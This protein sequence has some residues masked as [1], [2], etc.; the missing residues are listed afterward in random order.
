MQ[1]CR[2]REGKVPIPHG[3]LP[4]SESKLFI[5]NTDDQFREYCID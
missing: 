2:G 4:Y 1:M 3:D 5:L